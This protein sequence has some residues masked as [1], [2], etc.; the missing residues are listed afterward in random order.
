MSQATYTIRRPK[1]LALLA[2]A[3]KQEIIDVLA[4]MGDVSVAELAAALGRPADSLYFHLRALTRAGLVLDAGSRSRGKRREALFR[5]AAPEMRVQYEPLDGGRA[6]ALS[7]IVASMLR[8]GVRDFRRALRQTGIVAS[9]DRREIWALR[10]TGRLQPAQL[11]GV[12]RAIM[13]LVRALPE[14]RGPG[15]LYAITVLLTP[16]DRGRAHHKKGRKQ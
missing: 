14:P 10:R 7:A 8:L 12:N 15:R 13:R 3:R 4:G 2:S 1:E 6:D 5:A 16:L 11:A 9:G